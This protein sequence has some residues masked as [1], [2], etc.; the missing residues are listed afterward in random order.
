MHEL[1]LFEDNCNESEQ[2]VL[3]VF[4]VTEELSIDSEK[5]TEMV[6]PIETDDAESDGEVELTVGAVVSVVVVVVSSSVLVVLS[7]L[8]EPSSSL[9]QE[10]TVKLKR[11]M[12][13]MM[14]ICLTWFPIGGLGEPYLYQNLV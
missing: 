13:K 10:M 6:E 4:A 1:K 3:E 9:L 5:F 8:F 7:E 2:V 14:S 12:E 11:N